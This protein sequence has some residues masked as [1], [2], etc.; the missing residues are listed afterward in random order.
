M[1]VNPQYRYVNGMRNIAW[2]VG[3]L[4]KLDGGCFVQQNNNEE[5][6]L[7]LVVPNGFVLPS[8]KT[9]VEVA[10]HIY[11]GRESDEQQCTLKVIEV[12]RPSIRSMPPFATWLRGRETHKG[13]EFQPFLSAKE[14]KKEYVDKLKDDAEPSEHDKALAEW[15]RSSRNRMDSRF[16]EA[17]NKA[18]L[19]GFVG[20]T[21]FVPPNEFQ[22]HGY[23][24]IYL[25]QYQEPERAIPVRVY[26]RSV[27]SIM[28]GLRKGIPIALQGQVRMKVIPNDDGSVRSRNLHVRVEEVFAPDA[29]K[30]FIGPM[31]EWWGALFREV[32]AETRARS[33]NPAARPAA[34]AAQDAP[35]P[36]AEA[37]SADSAAAPDGA[38]STTAESAPSPEKAVEPA[39]LGVIGDL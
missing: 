28:K 7:P 5:H 33:G 37:A 31:P 22:T 36:A 2:V 11:G 18:F 26:N 8:D 9:P 6:M 16:G 38:A 17:S 27:L 10:C 34:V 15:F 39:S 24:E 19:A 20:A 12:S 4:R 30:D 3:Y 23:G 29:R 21:R 35:A 1:A 13:D 14:I 32:M 25:F